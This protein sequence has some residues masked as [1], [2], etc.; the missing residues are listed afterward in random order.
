MVDVFAF[1]YLYDFDE[2]KNPTVVHKKSQ[3]VKNDGCVHWEGSLH[4]DFV[5]D[6]ELSTKF[7]EGIE[8]LHLTTQERFEVAK[9]RNVEVATHHTEEKCQMTHVLGGI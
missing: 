7:I 4:E 6:R 2:Y 1:W 5:S 8:R 3:L 9:E